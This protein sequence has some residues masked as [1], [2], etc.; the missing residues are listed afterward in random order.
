MQIGW[1]RGTPS[2]HRTSTSPIDGRTPHSRNR[3]ICPVWQRIKA[4]EDQSDPADAEQN[5]DPAPPNPQPH[6][7]VMA[8]VANLD[9][10]CA[11]QFGYGR[12][13]VTLADWE[14]DWAARLR[15]LQ[16]DLWTGAYR[17][18]PLLWFDVPRREAG[19]TRRLGIPTVTDRVAQ[20][21]V[22]NVLEPLWEQV[23]L[24]CSH[25]F[26]PQRSVFTAIA[27]VLWHEARGLHWVVDADIK[28]CFD[29]I[30]H[31]RL[32]AQVAA[33]DDERI[34]DLIANWLDGHKPGAA[35][36]G[37][38]LAQGAVISPLLANIYLH[39][40]DVAMVSA[41]QALV[42]YA[43]DFVVMCADRQQ[44]AHTLAYV[45]QVLAGLDLVLNEAK[46]RILPFGPG[47]SF[48]GA[49]FDP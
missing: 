17:P 40:L 48:L 19:Q 32:L 49:Q 26:R 15:V 4:L 37:R 24:S 46:T 28:A 42:R 16:A 2:S 10:V 23:F 21:A 43:D 36:P 30:P 9:M 47:F 20:R 39:L 31:E 25:G 1:H 45:S 7:V 35:A 13:G 38:G 11:E 29:T 18:S 8:D 41:D 27:H 3:S 12:G 6:V 33:M 5:V 34:V 22:K 44:A 14:I